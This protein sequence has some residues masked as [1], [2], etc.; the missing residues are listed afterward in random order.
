MEQ[1][2]DFNGHGLHLVGLHDRLERLEDYEGGG[3]HPVRLSDCLG[4]REQYRVIHKLGSGGY[5]NVWLCRVLESSPTEYV[6]LKILMADASGD[7]CPERNMSSRLRGLTQ[8]NRAIA[9]YFCLP[10]QEFRIN[11]VDDPNKTLRGLVRQAAQAMAALHRAGI[12]HGDFRPHNILLRTSGLNGLSEDEALQ[13]LD[14][15]LIADVTNDAGESPTD[16]SAPVYLVYPVEYHPGN[17]ARASEQISVIDLG[18]A[19]EIT[20]PPV[21][22]G[23]PLP[24]AA[25]ETLFGSKAGPASDIWALACT[26]FEIRTGER[27]FGLFDDNKDDYFSLVAEM[28][29]PFP[30]SW[31]SSW[32]NRTSY[33]PD[34]PGPGLSHGRRTLRGE[35][36]KQVV[37]LPIEPA[38]EHEYVTIPE[39][40]QELF[41]DL[42][43]KMLVYDAEK[44]LSPNEVL[45]HPWFLFSAG[46]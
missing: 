28:L 46:S 8:D 3:H 42:L 20:N 36:R 16:A 37:H 18:E 14:Y 5:A 19:Y 26:M 17:C 22:L 11:V 34:T 6:A 21:K 31:W 27:L 39:E 4:N 1:D 41:A 43:E 2:D 7:G 9:Q 38:G 35:L 25:V 10:L 32:Q 13:Y 23:I 45:E 12:C 29:G 30:E 40:E 44:R 33:Y 24:Y 15:P